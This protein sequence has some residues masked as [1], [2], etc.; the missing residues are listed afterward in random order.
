MRAW[1]RATTNRSKIGADSLLF[2]SAL[3]HIAVQIVLQDAFEIFSLNTRY[4][5]LSSALGYIVKVEIG[6]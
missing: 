3:C 2:V 4:P 6:Q 5:I 1:S